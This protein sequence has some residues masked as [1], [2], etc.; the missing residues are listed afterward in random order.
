MKSIK[1]R[2]IKITRKHQKKNITALV[3]K[4]IVLK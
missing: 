1:F 3:K 4:P 2:K